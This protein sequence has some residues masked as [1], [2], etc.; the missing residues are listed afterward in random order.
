MTIHNK[1]DGHDNERKNEKEK[2]GFAKDEDDPNV[3]KE[4]KIIIFKTNPATPPKIANKLG[5]SLGTVYHI[6]KHSI[7]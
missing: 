7:T 3:V 5:V 2:R 4:I 6:I 1:K